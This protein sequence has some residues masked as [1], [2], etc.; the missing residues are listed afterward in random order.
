ML[1]HGSYIKLG[2]LQFV[3][4]IT[5]FATKQPKGDAAALAQASDSEEKLSPQLHQVPVLRSNSV[6]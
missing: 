3:F 1:H 4:S 2:C 6:P 5:E